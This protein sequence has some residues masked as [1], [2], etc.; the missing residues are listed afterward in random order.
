MPAVKLPP[1]TIVHVV[2]SSRLAGAERH[3]LDLAAA[4]AAAGHRVHVVGSDSAALRRAMPAGVEHHVLSLPLWRGARLAALARRLGADICHGH[5]GPACRAVARCT[6]AMRV[7]T[8]HIGYRPHQHDRLDGLICVNR[9]QWTT[10]SSY[11]GAARVVYNWPPRP[12]AAPSG[13]RLRERLGIGDD[14]VLVGTVARLHPSKGVDLLIRAFAQVAPGH[15]VLAILGEG[16]QERSLKRLAAGHPGIRFLGFR[17]DVDAALEDMDL[18][19]SPSREEA[20]PLAVLEAM[21]AGLP[22]VATR[23][24]GTMQLLGDAP[25]TLV[26]ID[27]VPALGA[28]LQ[29]RIRG[30][31]LPGHGRH[32]ARARVPYDMGLYDRDAAVARIESFYRAL[33]PSVAPRVEEGA[34]NAGET[35]GGFFA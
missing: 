25:A 19:V 1:L 15:A 20:L 27:D 24:Q 35:L 5:L 11:L 21:R 2:F 17:E 28:A 13:P 30:L 29:A 16:P 6:G 26:D 18:F 12:M 22:I 34:G 14:R 33:L 3:A 7:G 31:R 23:T 10:L 9:D 4:Q 8:L 32:G